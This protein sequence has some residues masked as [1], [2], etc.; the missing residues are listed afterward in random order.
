[1]KIWAVAMLVALTLAGCSSVSVVP[2]A[3]SRAQVTGDFVI[4]G[5]IAIR[6]NN[7]RHSAGVHW[8]HKA[9]MDEVLLLGPLGQ[10]AARVY[11]DGYGAT[12]ENGSQRYQADDA[13]T[14]MEK[15]LGWQLPLAGLPDWVLARPQPGSP[16]QIENDPAGRVARLRQSGWD[17]QYHRYADD[18]PESLP[19][20]LQLERGDLQV[21]LLI[22]EWKLDFP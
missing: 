9:S 22:D 5:R 19:T 16:A 18:T 2:S 20:R 15:V 12:L 7:E 8:S 3:T 6:H 10:T 1:M 11:R 14:L 4:N 17:V 21:Q 13:A